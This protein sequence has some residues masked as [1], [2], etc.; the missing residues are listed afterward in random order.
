MVAALAELGV[1]Y[2]GISQT[3]HYSSGA[4]REQI[5]VAMRER[6]RINAVLAR[7]GRRRRPAPRQSTNT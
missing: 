3:E 5:L 2:R 6:D 1:K 4:Y 7:T